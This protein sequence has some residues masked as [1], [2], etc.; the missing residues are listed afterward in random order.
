MNGKQE[1]GDQEEEKGGEGDADE[2]RWQEGYGSRC[3]QMITPKGRWNALA[4][5]LW[6]PPATLVV[7]F[8]FDGDV[9]FWL[10]SFLLCFGLF[11]S[12]L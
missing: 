6:E 4:A 2:R 8:G 7:R 3:P 11:F 10:G 12:W 9:C 1:G 5:L